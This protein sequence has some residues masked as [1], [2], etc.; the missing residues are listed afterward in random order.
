MIDMG[1]EYT[2]VHEK[3]VTK[4]IVLMLLFNYMDSGSQKTKTTDKI[5]RKK[6]ISDLIANKN[7]EHVLEEFDIERGRVRAD[8]VSIRNKLIHGYE[9][10]SDL[11][12]LMRLPEQVKYYNKVFSTVTLVVGSEHIVKALY[13]IP[14]W[15]GVVMARYD[16]NEVSLNVIRETRIN[17]NIDLNSVTELM[18]REELIRLLNEHAP[19]GAYSSMTKSR[20]KNETA[21]NIQKEDLMDY[22]LRVLVARKQLSNLRMNIAF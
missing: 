16:G 11:D 20:L 2:V 17:E 15:W 7:M 13:I 6:L 8:V 5:V 21:R 1:S 10:K 3:Y 12:T 19:G 22:L 4:A 9:I 14:E 18:K